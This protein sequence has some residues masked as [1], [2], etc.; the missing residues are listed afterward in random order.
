M[1]STEKQK[2]PKADVQAGPVADQ[3]WESKLIPCTPCG[4]F[5]RAILCPCEIYGQTAQRLRDP[6]KPAEKDNADCHEFACNHILFSMCF[7]EVMRHRSDIRK[8][9]NIKGSDTKD[10]LVS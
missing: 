5:W 1:A 10:C 6:T 4:H 8:R 9:Y 7:I 2:Q 3:E